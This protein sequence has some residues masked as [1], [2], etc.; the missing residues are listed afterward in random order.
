MVAGV[1]TGQSFDAPN[2]TRLCRSIVEAHQ[3]LTEGDGLSNLRL[4]QRI[5]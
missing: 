4:Q 2:E 3:P 5:P 1:A